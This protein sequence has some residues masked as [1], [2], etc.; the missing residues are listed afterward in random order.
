MSLS[1]TQ[2]NTL[3]LTLRSLLSGNRFAATP[4]VGEADLLGFWNQLVTDSGA[5]VALSAPLDQSI[6]YVFRA[7]LCGAVG[8]LPDADWA[9]FFTTLT[10]DATATASLPV[11]QYTEAKKQLRAVLSAYS[12]SPGTMSEATLLG[13]MATRTSTLRFIATRS[14][15]P[16]LTSN[17]LFSMMSRY[18]HFARGDITSIKVAWANWCADGTLPSIASNVL[19][20]AASIEYPAG[21]FTQVKF[22]GAVTGSANPFTT[23]W[24]DFISVSIPNGAEFW[25]RT[26]QTGTAG[27]LFTSS[28]YN[29]A[30]AEASVFPGTNQTMSGTVVPTASQIFGPCAIIGRTNNKAAFIIGD[31]RQAGAFD[32]GL[33]AIGGWGEMNNGLNAY[34]YCVNAQPGATTANYLGASGTIQALYADLAQYATDVVSCFGINDLN[35]IS[36]AALQTNQGLIRALSPTLKFHATTLNP[37]TSPTSS[38]NWATLANQIPAASNAQRVVYN[39]AVR[40]NGLGFD[41]GFDCAAVGESSL[42]SG[43]WQ[44]DGTAFKYTGDGLHPT[45]FT[46]GLYVSAGFTL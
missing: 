32:T 28:P 27:I 34:G 43:K 11:G 40:L 5:G 3:K 20:V 12:L 44:V 41:P 4:N 21:T 24:S 45:P 7:R 26:W 6:D 35:S 17:G 14:Q 29:P 46:C 10:T 8:R 31:S 33:S 1:A 39:T 16:T 25:V 13:Y 37:N 22:S 36:A 23:L 15:V 9:S 42:N 2:Y 18:G 30:I 19:S 38:D